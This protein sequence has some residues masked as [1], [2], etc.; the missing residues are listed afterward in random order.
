MEDDYNNILDHAFEK[1]AAYLI[2]KN[3]S[4]YEAIKG[5]T[6]SAAGTV[7]Y[8]GSQS[9]GTVDGTDCEAVVEAAINAAAGG[10]IHICGADYVI[11]D[12]IDVGQSNTW[13]S[14][15]GR[16]TKFTQTTADKMGF[17][18]TTKTNVRLSDLYLYGT[19]ADTGSGI[20]ALTTST[21]LML[22]RVVC[23]N[24]GYH[25]LHIVS[26]DYPRVSSCNFDSNIR[27]GILLDTVDHGTFRANHVLTNT[28]HG[29]E[30]DD[31]T[32]NKMMYNTIVGNDSAD[33]A[34]Y[35]GLYIG[36]SGDSS[37]YNLIAGNVIS[38]NDRY[39]IN[40]ATATC[41]GNKI[42]YNT[43][44]GTDR[45]AILNVHATA[46]PLTRFREL[47]FA[48]TNGTTRLDTAGAGWGWEID[49]DTEYAVATFML[50][51]EVQQ[52]I[53]FKVAAN[54]IVL[55]ADAM[56]LEIA[57]QGG[58]DNEAYNAE[59]IAVADKPSTSSNFVAG[60]Y[61][62]W[63]ITA[64]DDA[65]VDDFVG[66]DHV[67]FKVLHEAAGGDDCAT[68]AVFESVTVLYV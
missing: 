46:L 5:G 32:L 10:H 57:A 30:L 35:D 4:Y 53:A 41:T 38:D 61:V 8:G 62:Y 42:G 23:E 58:G 17:K 34:T 45:E 63:L 37:D 3:G 21:G 24:W 40:I 20:Y 66:G 49:L 7:V 67:Q 44:Y 14:G 18:L 13:I 6:S 29:V 31:C 55:E 36:H 25:G 52:V 43:L 65:D 12:E 2:R 50:P 9:L 48:F 54:S 22:D 56:R 59:A 11:T 26:S 68:D 28:R 1:T 33:A 27:N 51:L 47:P 15:D 64:S 60:D 39:E 19:G 16:D